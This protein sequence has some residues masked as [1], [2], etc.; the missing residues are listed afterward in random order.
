MRG[1]DVSL[2]LQDYVYEHV[3][4]RG[5]LQ[6]LLLALAF[7]HTAPTGRRARP[8]R[9]AA[10]HH[11]SH[12][13][14]LLRAGLRAL[15]QVHHPDHGGDDATM[16]AVLETYQGLCAPLKNTPGMRGARAPPTRGDRVCNS[17]ANNFPLRRAK[18][19][20]ELTKYK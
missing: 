10:C 17:A 9:P 2:K 7:H 5:L 11:P 20:I 15:A 18:P 14:Q 8:G 12:A 6:R 4:V 1:S 16:R 19:M 3:D 13:A